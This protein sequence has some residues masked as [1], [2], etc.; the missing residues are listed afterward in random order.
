MDEK[1]IQN[2]NDL[3]LNINN[4]VKSK[5]E[6]CKTNTFIIN[7]LL[8]GYLSKNPKKL[9]DENKGNVQPKMEKTQTINPEILRKQK[10]FASKKYYTK[11]ELKKKINDV[12]QSKRRASIKN[13]SDYQMNK[14]NLM[15]E[16]N[17]S[18]KPFILNESKDNEYSAKKKK[19]YIEYEDL[20]FEDEMFIPESSSFPNEKE[21]DFLLKLKFIEENDYNDDLDDYDVRYCS[22]NYKSN[23]EGQL[24]TKYYKNPKNDN[25]EKNLPNL[26]DNLY[27]EEK[28]EEGKNI[29]YVHDTNINTSLKSYITKKSNN[30]M[31]NSLNEENTKII[32]YM[33]INLLVKKITLENFRNKYSFIYKC[34]IE[35][36]R[37]FIPI[38][39]LVNKIFSAF[40]YY[41][42]NMKLDCTELIL[43]LNTLIY[44]NLE[45]IK[46]DKI[47]LK[48]LCDFYIKIMQINWNNDTINQ[49]L[50]TLDY[51]LFNPFKNLENSI[52]KNEIINSINISEAKNT[53]EDKKI[54]R[55]KRLL[56]KRNTEKKVKYFYIFNFKSVEI[57][58]YLTCE[59]YQLYSNIPESELYNKNF[60]RKDKNLKSPNIKKIFERYDKLTYF[61]IEDICS[62]DNANERVDAIEKWIRVAYKCFELKNFSDLIMLNTLFCHYLLKK[63]LKKTW[64]KLSK[65]ALNNL[66][67]FNRFC[68]ADQCY[69]KIR[70]EIFRSKGP[71][72]PYIAILLKQLIYI[73]E[74]KYMTNN[75]INVMKLVE[76]N[77][78]IEKFFEFK[79]YK[80]PFDKPKNLE[81]LSNIYPKNVEEIE[82]I[83]KQLEPKL[84][85]HSIKGD[86][87]RLTNTDKIFYG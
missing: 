1:I 75:N 4:N 32:S 37:Y 81:V 72:I 22:I 8:G 68:S 56:I 34:F 82:A 76:I 45:I 67:K 36:F 38:N 39:N 40:N 42:E 64:A 41:H 9:D 12:F 52:E 44:E 63:K 26:L 49:D 57:A 14:I 80:Y 50:K 54:Q 19:K 16:N 60:D 46:E 66:D 47:T 61:I 58:Q 48:Q 11:K 35:Q 7:N 13:F 77:K 43:F 10:L 20:Y 3:K 18:G 65:K 23:N 6:L 15:N 73:E 29:C 28:E 85:I 55:A 21:E 74:K 27:I 69:K 84:L 53:N 62:Y 33:S 17:Q 59:S 51:L 30:N 86:K 2:N 79:K 5:D 25:S 70:N 78:T 31:N 83:T 24:Y 87:K 71:Y